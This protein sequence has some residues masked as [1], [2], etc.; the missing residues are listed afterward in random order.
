MYHYTD[1]GLDN[2]FLESGY[3][4][5]ETTYGAGVEI[6]DIDGLHRA[7]GKW[8]LSVPRDLPAQNFASFAMS[9][10]CPRDA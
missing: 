5:I 1:S 9:S 2:I 8:L 6:E 7:I 3:E 10:T 4:E